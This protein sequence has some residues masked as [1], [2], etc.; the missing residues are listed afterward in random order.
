[1]LRRLVWVRLASASPVVPVVPG[2]GPATYHTVVLRVRP[3][4]P[5]T[6]TVCTPTANGPARAAAAASIAILHRL[7][8]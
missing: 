8:G 3:S 2:A 1:M 7:K 6:A 5:A 4:G